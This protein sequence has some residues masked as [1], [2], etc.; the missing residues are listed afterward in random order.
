[1][2][3]FE[4]DESGTKERFVQVGIVHGGVS[5]CGNDRYPNIYTRVEDPEI[6]RFIEKHLGMDSYGIR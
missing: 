2:K 4:L 3:S 5:E 1:M 6:F